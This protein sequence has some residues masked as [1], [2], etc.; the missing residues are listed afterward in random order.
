[1]ELITHDDLAQ[2]ASET[3]RRAFVAALGASAPDVS[4]DVM[5]THGAP[6]P[7]LVRLAD[8]DDDLLVV[9]SRQRTL[10][11]RATRGSTAQYCVTHA[12]CPVVVVPYALARAGT[13]RA[14]SRQ[15]QRELRRL[16]DAA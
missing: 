13:K 3:V 5:T 2:E 4:V 7:E 16:V 11:G 6:G 10:I 9:G 15:L 1:M 12:N 8:R 14:S